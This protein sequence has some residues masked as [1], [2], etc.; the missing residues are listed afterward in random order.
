MELLMIPIPILSLKAILIIL[1]FYAATLAWLVWTLRIIFS[2]KARRRLGPGRSVVYV[3]F[4]AMSCV[5]VWY[6]YDLRQPTAEFKMKFEPVLSERSLIGGINMPAG[7]KLVVN[8]PYDFETFREAEFP[9]PVRISGTDALRAERYLTIE[10]DEDYRTRGYTPL[11]I[12][13]TGNGEGLENEWRCDAT[14]P[15]VLKTHSD[16]SI[17]DFESCMAADGNL[18]ENQPLPKGA[19]IIAIDGTVYTDGFVASDRWLVYLPAGAEFTVGDTSQMGG[20]I[21]LDAKRRIIT[22]PLR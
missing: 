2:V 9:Y 10:T 5:T 16:G 20:M 4:M 11:N 3:I 14:H 22:K 8:A 15:I 18:I 7:T 17:K 19:E 12:R 6:H 1:A 13:L 21:R